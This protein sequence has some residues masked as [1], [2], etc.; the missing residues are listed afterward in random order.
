HGRSSVPHREEYLASKTSIQVLTR[1]TLAVALA[2]G[3]SSGSNT[4]CSTRQR[5]CA[6]PR[7]CAPGGYHRWSPGDCPDLS[8]YQ[9]YAPVKNCRYTVTPSSYQSSRGDSRANPEVD[10]A[11]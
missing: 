2:H 5:L 1:A 4:P 7:R 10:S 3:N 8:G 11:R 9:G 6:W